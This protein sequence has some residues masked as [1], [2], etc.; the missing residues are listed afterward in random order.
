MTSWSG[1]SIRNRHAVL[2]LAFGAVVFGLMAWLR[3]PVALNPETAP[4][5]VNIVV[6]YP[7]VTAYD[8]AERVSRPVEEE[9]ATLEGI[10]RVA[11]RSQD[12]V[13]VVTA[14]FQYGV[15]ADRAAV[16]A[17]NAV[18][19]IRG[20]LPSGIGEPRVLKFSTADRPIMTLAVRPVDGDLTHAREWAEDQMRPMLQ[21]LQGVAAVDI[22]GG[23]RRQIL[24]EVDRDRLNAAGLRLEQVARAIRESA[25]SAPVGRVRDAQSEWVLRLDAEA[26]TAD[27]VARIPVAARLGGGRVLVGD[28]AHVRDGAADPESAFRFNGKDGV[29]VQIIQQAGANTVAVI[30][31]VEAFLPQLRERFPALDIQIAAEEATFTRRVVNNMGGSILSA[32][33]LA[34]I[35]IYLFLGRPSGSLIITLSMPLSFLLTFAAMW[36]TGMELNL[37]TLTA[38]VLAVGM[39]V[40]AAVVV[41]ENI[42][43]RH[44]EGEAMDAAASAGADEVLGAVLAGAGTTMIVL[45]PFLFLTGFVGMVFGSLAL[46]L[47]YALA[48]SVLV[49]LTIVPLLSVL[50]PSGRSGGRQAPPRLVRAFERLMMRL[51]DGYV[52]VLRRALRRRGLVLLMSLLALG[53]SLALLRGIGREVLPGF[54]TG[55][56]FISIETDPGSSLQQTVRVAEQIERV[57]DRQPH[58]LAYTA[59]IGFEPEARSMDTTGAMGAQQAFFEVTLNTRKERSETIW[60]VLDALRADVA[61]I[62]GIRTAV[63]REMGGT[64]R[65]TTAAPLEIEITGP[66]L[67]VLDQLAEEGRALLRSVPGV[68]EPYRAWHADRVET[69]LR[70]DGQ[71]AAEQDLRPSTLAAALRSGVE[72]LD[73][74]TLNVP[75][76]TRPPIVVRYPE[77]ERRE[78]GMALDY[79]VAPGVPAR[80]VLTQ[81]SRLSPNLVTRENLFPVISISAYHR[82]R[83]FSHVVRDI[84]TAFEAFEMPSG[85]GWR[86]A[87]EQADLETSQRDMFG[88]LA[89]ALIAVYLLLVTQFRSFLHPLT[90]MLAIPLVIIGVA[91]ALAVAGKSVSMSVLVALILLAGI[92]VNNSILIMHFILGNRDGRRDRETIVL[93]AVRLRFRPIMMTALSTIAGMLP[94]AL[95]WA[96]GA[97]R[98]S[99]LAIA[100]VGGLAAST[101]LTMIV[102][103]VFYTLFDDLASGTSVEKSKTT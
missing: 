56:L 3:L 22:F 57:L 1:F 82:G 60:D 54:D 74:G 85:Y 65:A 13:S 72:G 2:A 5:L 88:A 97:E 21:S 89:V 30:E 51:R 99:P 39:V 26:D 15:D 19:R 75:D 34:G 8:V 63:L 12:G 6:P 96:L 50:L 62:P 24:V 52:S 102:I 91:P 92:A 80:A 90:V 76:G 47:L 14:E 18:A 37:V 58:V 31:R 86:I 84:Q 68:T 59:R 49:A 25:L 38:L 4:P 35:V 69:R 71:R 7:G 73:A 101:F 28:V 20:R 93:D 67:E 61:R 42:L 77:T 48:A 11:S 78:P 66:D 23:S 70:V 29:S 79:P 32:I 94:L 95:E 33:L 27:H 100:V 41:L 36:L 17:Q 10:A 103:P 43:R 81:E 53:A 45:I 16:D 64:A 9:M 40:D 87:G 98:F 55:T 83:P 44:A 46:T